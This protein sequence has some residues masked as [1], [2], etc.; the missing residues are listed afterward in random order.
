MYPSR[1]ASLA[2]AAFGVLILA[3]CSSAEPLP[4]TSAPDE[5]TSAPPVEPSPTP[6]PS[7]DLDDP[8]SWTVTHQGIGPV[9]LDGDF[10]ATLSELPEA[11][12]NDDH[13][14]WAAWWNAEDQSYSV[15]FVRGTESEDEPIVLVSASAAEP[16]TPG[17]GPR[18]DDGLGIGS[19]KDEVRMQHPDAAEGQSQIGEGSWLS[20]PGDGGTIFFEYYT[21]EATQANAVTVTTLEEPPYETC[22]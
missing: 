22:G 3:G 6:E 16:V 18:T 13:C 8:A 17:V 21:A 19:T 5:A 7:T 14:S 2:A 12:E 20:V 10:A 15:D 11:W 9:E 1:A 4:Q